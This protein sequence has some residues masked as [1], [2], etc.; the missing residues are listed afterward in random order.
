[1]AINPLDLL[2][3]GNFQTYNRKVAKALGSIN[4][5]ILLSELV[6]RY[7]YHRDLN[8]LLHYEKYP[9]TWFYYT[10]EKC[11]ERTVL[12]RKEQETAIKILEKHGLFE[13]R[14]IGIPPKRHFCLNLDRIHEFIGAASNNV[15]KT[16]EKG[17]M[18]G[19]KGAERNDRKGPSNKEPYKE[20]QERQQQEAPPPSV[21]VFSCLDE[22]KIPY[23]MKEKLSS[24]MDEEKAHKLVRRVKAWKGRESDAK[25][26]NTILAQWE[27]WEDNVPKE[28]ILE[29]NKAWAENSLKKFQCMYNKPKV[30]VYSCE[31][32][33][34]HVEFIAGTAQPKCFMYKDASFQK[35][36]TEFIKNNLK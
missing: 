7:Q 15:Y 33:S 28:E 1:M 10:V 9:G 31:V 24:H 6:N 23:P 11:E 27:T 29:V 17:D 16:P 21:V 4:A 5:A 25:A 32:L 20:P 3:S 30:G 35:E 13:K 26:C 14:S 12:S 8:E 19:P 36:V 22:L 34:K 18:K 2:D